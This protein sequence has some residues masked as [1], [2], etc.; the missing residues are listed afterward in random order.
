MET[1]KL[2]KISKHISL[3]I[4]KNILRYKSTKK[5]LSAVYITNKGFVPWTMFSNRNCCNDA[6]VLLYNIVQC[7]IK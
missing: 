1:L 2:K 5:R 7:N 3:I 4:E 6:S